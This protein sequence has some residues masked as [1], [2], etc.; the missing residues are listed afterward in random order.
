MDK[1]GLSFS[2]LMDLFGI[3]VTV[4]IP[5]LGGM[6]HLLYIVYVGSAAQKRINAARKAENRHLLKQLRTLTD[7]IQKFEDNFG[8]EHSLD[9]FDSNEFP[10]E[11]YTEDSETEEDNE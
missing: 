1:G 8:L 3:L 10:A 6:L 5:L 7:H 4:L 9:E 11:I 2:D